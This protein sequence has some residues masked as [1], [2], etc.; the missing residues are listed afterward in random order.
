MIGDVSLNIIAQN[1]LIKWDGEK[2]VP[3]TVATIPKQSQ[4]LDVLMGYTGTDSST[5]EHTIPSQIALVQ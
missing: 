2:L 3:T 5:T 1:Q 4:V